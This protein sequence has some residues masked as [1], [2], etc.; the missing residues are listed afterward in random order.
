MYI[1]QYILGTIIYASSKLHSDINAFNFVDRFTRN[2]FSLPNRYTSL[3]FSVVME[4]L[5]SKLIMYLSP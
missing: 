2:N 4:Y 3:L 1:I 5:L